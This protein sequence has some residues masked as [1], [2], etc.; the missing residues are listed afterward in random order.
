MIGLCA[1][2][3]FA[4]QADGQPDRH[5]LAVAQA[6][7]L[8]A[9]L[10]EPK[11]FDLTFEY[12]R[13]SSALG[14][15][16]GAIGALERVLAFAP[17]LARADFELGTLYFRLGSYDNAIHYFKAAAAAPDLDPKLRARLTVYLPEVE[18]QLSPVS[19]SGFLQTGLGYQ[20]NVAALPNSGFVSIFGQNAPQGSGV[21][22]KS[23]GEAFGLAKI[24]NIYDFENQRGDT[25]ETNFIGYGTGQFSLHQFDLA[26]MEASIGPRLALDPV[27][28]PGVTIKPYAIGNV[29]WVGGT[30][31]LNSG[32]AGVSLGIDT[33]RDWSVAPDFEWRHISVHN[34]GAAQITALGTGDFLSFSIAGTY[35]F[36]DLISV[37]VQPIY[38]RANAFNAWQSFNQGGVTAG[39]NVEFNPPFPLIPLQWTVMPYVSALWDRF[40]APDPAVN[41]SLRR[42]DFAY[43]GGVMLDMPVTAS[44]GVSG[45]VQYARTNSNLQ[46]F[47]NDD[48]T[49][50]FGPT[51]RF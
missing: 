38:S 7:L 33:A 12:V 2:L 44:F 28:W 21:A 8:A 20:S 40:D 25:I 50:L 27:N 39:L 43:Y 16:E 5:T 41:A 31:Y 6:R 30:S 23:D 3:G 9:V 17:N 22:Q 15:Y 51:A 32:G 49:I 47:T 29:S 36:T 46:N 37:Q 19:W 24:S 13:V 18:K 4:A 1:G 45:T 11:N 34:P 14:D 42:C 10:R 26:Y 35:R 48:V